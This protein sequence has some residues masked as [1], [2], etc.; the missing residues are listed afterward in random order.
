MRRTP[1]RSFSR[2]LQSTNVHL[3]EFDHRRVDE[4]C[5]CCPLMSFACND[6]PLPRLDAHMQKKFE[7][8]QLQCSQLLAQ[9]QELRAQ[10][11]LLQEKI[12]NLERN[13]IRLIQRWT[14]QV[15][16][17]ACDGVCAMVI[18]FARAQ[19][20]RSLAERTQWVSTDNRFLL[21]EEILLLKQKLYH[22]YDDFATVF[23]RNQSLEISYGEQRQ[24]LLSYK[25]QLKYERLQP[26]RSAR[27]VSV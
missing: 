21:R 19:D 9:N 26:R 18:C 3:R 12:D 10:C 8:N 24:Q 20:L 1:S 2:Q 22:V 16:D 14:Q 27:L 11:D 5:A 4:Q 17:G 7:S 6:K 23:N 13:N 25:Q 15:S